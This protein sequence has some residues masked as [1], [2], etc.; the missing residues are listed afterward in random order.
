[1]ATPITVDGI[2]NEFQLVDSL[3][4]RG[5]MTNEQY[6]KY[7]KEVAVRLIQAHGKTAP[8]PW[9]RRMMG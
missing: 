6:D 5:Y 7:K 8:R 1:M 9:W 3:V 2:L 4:A